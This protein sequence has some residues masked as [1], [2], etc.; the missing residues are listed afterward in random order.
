[1]IKTL[2]AS[3]N[4]SYLKE[5][6]LLKRQTS[7]LQLNT[8]LSSAGLDAKTVI[9]IFIFIVK[10]KYNNILVFVVNGPYMLD[11]DY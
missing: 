4:P 2:R 1:M 10:D 7:K 3:Q 5:L 9:V 8:T 6:E 11:C